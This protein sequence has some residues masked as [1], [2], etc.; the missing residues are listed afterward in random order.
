MGVA[1]PIHILLADDEETFLYATA[2]LLR[3]EGYHCDCAPDGET[4]AK[5]LQKDDYDLLIADIR[6]PGN[7]ELELIR[8]LP[9]IAEGLPVILV[10]G[11]PSMKTALESFHLPVAAYLPKPVDWKELLA[12]VQNTARKSNLFRMVREVRERLHRREEDLKQ[13]EAASLEL[14][15]PGASATIDGFL[16]ITFQNLIDSMGDLKSLVQ[17]LSGGRSEQEVCHLWACPRLSLLKGGLSEAIEVLEKT[18]NSF[19][20]KELGDLRKR[21]EALMKNFP[22]KAE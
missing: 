16:T 6:M 3:K 1:D 15:Q 5:M 12:C 7:G 14:V 2:D 8:D 17:M 19:R 20:S 9:R 21:L 22:E 18:K 11:Y 4:A 13:V 10:T